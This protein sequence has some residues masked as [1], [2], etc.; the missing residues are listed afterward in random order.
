MQGLGFRGWKLLRFGVQAWR[1]LVFKSRV[2]G[3][4]GLG[5]RLVWGPRSPDMQ[6]H[7]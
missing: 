2:G 3:L 5:L 4:G 6:L 1:A 7:I